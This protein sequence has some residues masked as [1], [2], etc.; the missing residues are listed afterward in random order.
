MCRRVC[1]FGCGGQPFF[2]AH[3]L[4]ERYHEERF[5]A[6]LTS[7]LTDR[8]QDGLW[9]EAEVTAVLAGNW[10]RCPE[11]PWSELLPLNVSQV[12][13]R[14]AHYAPLKE[15]V[16]AAFPQFPTATD[17][18]RYRYDLALLCVGCK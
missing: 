18:G 1:V 4:V 5:L 14:S 10:T 6:L 15:C 8:N 3:Y 2:Y 12:H 16:L 7:A 13:A 9:E 11:V 17:Q